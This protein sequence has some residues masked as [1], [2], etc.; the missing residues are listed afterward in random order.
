MHA[1]WPHPIPLS[2]PPAAMQ[3]GTHA[4]HLSCC[5]TLSV[6]CPQNKRYALLGAFAFGQG[7]SVGPLVE[8]ALAI[9]PAIVMTAALA[10]SAIFASFT[11][12]AL[13]TKRRWVPTFGTYFVGQFMGLGHV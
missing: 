12:S 2:A 8:A 7:L 9:S 5:C 6:C 10:T 13:V 3:H 11:L 1:A 4:P